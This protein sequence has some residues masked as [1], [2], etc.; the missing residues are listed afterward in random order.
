[1]VAAAALA[2][3]W[4]PIIVR[5][6]RGLYG[7]LAYVPFA[8][9][10]SLALSPNRI[11]LLL[12]DILFVAPAY[13]GL[14][15]A[16]VVRRERLGFPMI[17]LALMGTLAILV[18]GQVLGP[19]VANILMTV[20]GLKVWL[21]YLPLYFVAFYAIRSCEDLWRIMRLLAALAIV[22]C[23]V[24]LS[25]YVLAL[26][27]GYAEVMTWFYGELAADVTQ[28]FTT[29]EFGPG[30]LM[31]IPSTFSFAPQYWG[32]TLAM[33]VPCYAVWRGD[34]SMRWRRVAGGVFFLDLAAGTLSG[35]RAAFIFLP[36]LLGTTVLLDRK[37]RAIVVFLSAMVPAAVVAAAGL[38]FRPLFNHVYGLFGHYARDVAYDGLLTALEL[39][40]F[41]AGTGTNT[42]PA[43]YAIADPASFQ[44]IESYYAKA[45][46]ELG[47]LGLILIVLLFGWI[48]LSGWKV[49]RQVE[50]RLRP[51]AA[52][53][54]AFAVCIALNSFKGWQLD[55]DPIN[56]YF[57][58][59][60]G[61]LNRIAGLDDSRSRR[62][63][64]QNRAP[65]ALMTG[66]PRAAMVSGCGF[67]RNTVPNAGDTWLHKQ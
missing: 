13:I 41:G 23:V 51:C 10:V 9:A 48:I 4:T 26:A 60:A 45:V 33:L 21:F 66:A 8:G 2:G 24:G 7:L 1:M 58:V 29:F 11:P 57:W 38:G 52:A 15:A 32:F 28:G 62:P 19:S 43:R 27:F 31:R 56:V 30:Y 3:L 50:D 39:A 40:P 59:F 53:L 17:P 63:F 12:K 54:T 5:W 6:Q 42:G 36:L 14:V 22:P 37:T 49:T 34:P 61:I 44:A 35:S 47:F 55:L 67:Y 64:P 65:D 46:Y 18:G 16:L 25:E 20:I